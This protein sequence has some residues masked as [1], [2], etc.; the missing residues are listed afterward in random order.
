MSKP[1]CTLLDIFP[2]FRAMAV[3]DLLPIAV[4]VQN[5]ELEA[6]ISYPALGSKLPSE[7]ILPIC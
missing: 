6:E 2:S 3:V 7:M 4:Q 5:L 1:S